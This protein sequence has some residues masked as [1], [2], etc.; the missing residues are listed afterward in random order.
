M[1]VTQ[2]RKGGVTDCSKHNV[3]ILMTNYGY[4]LLGVVYSICFS[5]MCFTLQRNGGVTYSSRH[6]VNIVRNN[7]SFH[8]AVRHLQKALCLC[9]NVRRH[10]S[11]LTKQQTR[12]LENK[13]REAATVTET[14]CIGVWTRRRLLTPLNA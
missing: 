4:N 3:N 2:K 14:S 10:E 5:S 9:M 6:N 13:K 12:E 1:C 11:Q 8:C 7:C